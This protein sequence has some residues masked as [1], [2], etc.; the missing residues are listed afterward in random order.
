MDR[1]YDFVSVREQC[2]LLKLNRSTLYY[3]AA[4]TNAET[5]ELM[6]L[7]DEIFLEHPY[8]GARRIRQIL[9]R[10]GKQ[11]TRKRIRRLMKLMG[12][13]TLYR[14]PRTSKANPENKT[15]SKHWLTDRHSQRRRSSTRMKE[16]SLPKK[17]SLVRC[18]APLPR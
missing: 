1:E 9:K 17:T 12:L 8:F 6:R 5:L 10:E 14:K 3:K 11:V 2:E 16:A 13:E 4:E 7:I 15:V 18:L